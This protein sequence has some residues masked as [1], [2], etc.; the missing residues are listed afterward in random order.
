MSAA[1]SPR[2]RAEMVDYCPILFRDARPLFWDRK[3]PAVGARLDGSNSQE[4]ENRRS[5]A[6]GLEGVVFWIEI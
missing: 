1:W 3:R 5:F 2:T 4:T 6:A